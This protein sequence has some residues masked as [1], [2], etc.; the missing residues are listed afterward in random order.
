MNS[1]PNRLVQFDGKMVDFQ[2]NLNT[3]S[4][5]RLALVDV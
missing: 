5:L 2:L 3:V 1:H 4:G